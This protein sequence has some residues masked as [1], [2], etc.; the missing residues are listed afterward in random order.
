MLLCPKS[1][2]TLKMTHKLTGLIAT[3][4]W[5]LRNK[6]L[7]YITKKHAIGVPSWYIDKQID[8]KRDDEMLN[9]YSACNFP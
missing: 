5:R 4:M 7:T 6:R 1:D 3:R 2:K 8:K 9:M